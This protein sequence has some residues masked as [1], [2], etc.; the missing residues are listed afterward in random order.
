MHSA[1]GIIDDVH[2]QYW[3][4]KAPLPNNL[5]HNGAGHHMYYETSGELESIITDHE[6][7]ALNY[8]PWKSNVSRKLAALDLFCGGG[9]FGHGIED[10]GVAECR[11]SVDV[12][13][14]ALLTY[15]YNHN[16]DNKHTCYNTSVNTLLEESLNGKGREDWPEPGEVDLILA[17]NPCQGFSRMNSF[18]NE[19]NSVRKSSLFAS[20][21][22]YIEFYKPSYFLLENVANL[23]RFN[24]VD[25]I[26]STMQL[27]FLLRSATSFWTGAPEDAVHISCLAL[28][29]GIVA[30]SHTAFSTVTI[31]DAIE[32]LP[33]IGDGSKPCI[34][35]VD[36]EP[37]SISLE[38]QR[39]VEALPTEPFGM[40]LAQLL[41]SNPKHE[42]LQHKWNNK[43][44]KH[45]DVQF[46]DYGRVHRFKVMT[47]VLTTFSICGIKSAPCFHYEEP[48]L[49]TIRE[50][51]RAQGFLD[52]DVILGSYTDKHRIVG[53][54]V[55][56]PLAFALGLQLELTDHD[57]K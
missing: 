30:S 19:E 22:S 49:L 14:H 4:P 1:T 18:Y 24:Y 38:V 11:W 46:R 39:I 54:A 34:Q 53:N 32:D 43:R 27:E 52:S 9:N 2:I 48:R 25:F 36:H 42:I 44:R 21:A 40:N 13:Y 20:V 45:A 33:A 16:Q 28:S 3:D 10:S 8:P 51:A 6:T 31:H 37:K 15:R 17:G 26:R 57:S 41:D 12:D 56:R 5:A 35:L 23:I 55:P 29:T 47:T 50:L 7:W